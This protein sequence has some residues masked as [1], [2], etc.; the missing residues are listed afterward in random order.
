VIRWFQASPSIPRTVRKPGD[1]RNEEVAEAFSICSVKI[2][3]N[4][5][6]FGMSLI[7]NYYYMQNS[8]WSAIFPQREQFIRAGKAT[9]VSCVA[10]RQGDTD[11]LYY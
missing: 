1:C 4:R 9:G 2:Q 11:V 6:P 3:H 8:P 10:K 7:P 5:D